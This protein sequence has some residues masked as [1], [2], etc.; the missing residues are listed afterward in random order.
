M[1]NVRDRQFYFVSSLPGGKSFQFYGSSIF[2]LSGDIARKCTALFCRCIP[3]AITV[4]SD[5]Y[6]VR[7]GTPETPKNSKEPIHSCKVVRLEAQ[8]ERSQDEVRD[9]YAVLK[10][11]KAE[12]ESILN[13]MEQHKVVSD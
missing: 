5:R 4:M 11:V 6:M 12:S 3:H 8:G 7:T 1:D 2:T 9:L 13:I 10:A